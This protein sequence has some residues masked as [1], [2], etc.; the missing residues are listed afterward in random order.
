MV[1]KSKRRALAIKHGYRSGLEEDVAK[2]LTKKG[3][4]FEYETRKIKW[5]DHKVRTYTPD[6]ILPNSIIVELK[7]RFVAADRRKHLE[8][9][10]Q[11]P[12][13]DIRFVFQNPNARLNKVSKTTYRQWCKRHGFECAYLTIPQEW[14]D[15]PKLKWRRLP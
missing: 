3:V 8:I 11:Y 13:Y 9:K 2:E 5:T 10:K 15:E 6:I 14:I 12:E 4:D 7:G 1:T